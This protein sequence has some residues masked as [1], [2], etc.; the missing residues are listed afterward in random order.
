MM[1]GLLH[2][3]VDNLL[4]ITKGQVQYIKGNAAYN[5]S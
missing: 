4:S 5:I 2:L 1:N 3:D